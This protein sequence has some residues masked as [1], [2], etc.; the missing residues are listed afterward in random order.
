MVLGKLSEGALGEVT[1]LWAGLF[2]CLTITAVHIEVIEHMSFSASYQRLFIS[3]PFLHSS[4][5][6]GTWE[7]MTG[8]VRRI[9]D[10]MLPN[11]K[12]LTHDVLVTLMAEDNSRPIVPLSYD[13]E[14]SE[15]LT[16]ELL[17]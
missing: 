11:V 15:L 9:L 8:I 10:S 2:T 13:P 12:T 16:P 6:N 4:H 1:H 14:T 17:Y 3:V 7:R 5:M